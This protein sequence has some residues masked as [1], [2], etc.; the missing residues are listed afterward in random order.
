MLKAL[1]GVQTH[2][3]REWVPV[4]ENSQDYRILSQEVEASLSRHSGSHGFFLKAH[5][6]Y[7]WGA[8]IAEAR[9]HVEALDFWPKS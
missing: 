5:G 1:A 7:T 8:D 6:L 9:R 4:L 3:H 2:L